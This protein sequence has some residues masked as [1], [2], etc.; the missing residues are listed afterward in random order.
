[1]P[2][3]GL[4]PD[5]VAR[6]AAEVA[7]RVG[8]DVLSLSAVAKEVGVSQPALYKHVDGLDGLR[9][10]V[11]VLAVDELTERIAQARDGLRGRQALQAI[12]DAY[13]NYGRRHPG[14][15]AAAVRAPRPDDAD[16]VRAGTAAVAQVLAVLADYGL[17]GSDAIHGVRLFRAALHGFVVLENAGGFGLPESLDETFARLVDGLDHTF[18]RPA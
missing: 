18:R 8:F 1:M 17:E 16:H 5:R 10:D 11:A 15:A 6:V 14:R 4:T 12:A 13:R 7:D 2:R 9:R 3:A